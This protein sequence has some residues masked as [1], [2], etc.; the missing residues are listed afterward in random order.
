MGDPRPG[1]GAVTASDAAKQNMGRSFQRPAKDH[2][3]H[4][5]DPTHWVAEGQSGQRDPT[6]LDM[7]VLFEENS[8]TVSILRESG[9]TDVQIFEE[10]NKLP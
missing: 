7:N 5:A 8:R 2:Q 9:L 1:D 3:D 6:A 10:L 4:R